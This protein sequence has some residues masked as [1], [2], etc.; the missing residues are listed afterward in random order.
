MSLTLQDKSIK[1]SQIM[2]LEYDKDIESNYC[3]TLKFY[4]DIFGSTRL[5]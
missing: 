5:H 4:I 3:I 2:N 1:L